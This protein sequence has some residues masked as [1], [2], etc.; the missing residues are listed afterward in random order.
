MPA[1]GYV[2]LGIDAK[3][4]LLTRLTYNGRENNVPC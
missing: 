3:T 1:V 4:K 2:R